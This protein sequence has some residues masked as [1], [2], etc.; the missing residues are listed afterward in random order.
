M[1]DPYQ[2]D[3]AFRPETYW[4]EGFAPYAPEDDPPPVH[5]LDSSGHVYLA[6]DDS[7]H[8]VSFPDEVP[9]VS[10]GT[11]SS[12]DDPDMLC[13]RH[14]DHGNIRYRYI[15]DEPVLQGDPATFSP[16]IPASE[17]PLTFEELIFSLDNTPI[18]G[19]DF[20]SDMVGIMAYWWDAGIDLFTSRTGRLFAV[21]GAPRITSGVYPELEAFYQAVGR[22]YIQTG[23]LAFLDERP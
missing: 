11:A 14:D 10:F 15:I 3:L 2:F 19:D 4:P 8:W 9:V 17:Q 22:H 23:E 21:S 1:F 18:L 12:N 7:W 13:A 20:D 16:G 5:T 6:A